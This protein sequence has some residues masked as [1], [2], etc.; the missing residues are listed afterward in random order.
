MSK[1]KCGGDE[2]LCVCVPRGPAAATSVYAS[3][4]ESAR[5]EVWSTK[6]REVSSTVH[7]RGKQHHS[8]LVT[9]RAT[10]NSVT[11]DSN[12]ECYTAVGSITYRLYGCGSR[13][14]LDQK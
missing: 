5:E 7:R 12:T 13:Q 9:I 6:A 10:R 11:G 3:V 1:R 2:A 8:V 4:S 14:D